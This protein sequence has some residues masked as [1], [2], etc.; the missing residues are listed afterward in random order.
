M[1]LCHGWY[2][3]KESLDMFSIS[4]GIDIVEI[5]R[6]EK[7]YKKFNKKFINR[8][9]SNEEISNIQFESLSK[10]N[11]ANF[12]AARYACKEACAKAA[13]TGFSNGLKFTDFKIFNDKLGKPVLII[14]EKVRKM[15]KK[16]FHSTISISHEK[17]FAIASVIFYF[18]KNK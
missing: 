17:R 3:V 12:L 8:I 13:G 10:T 9:L 5:K 4:H 15:I 2:L 7:V 18:P 11:I 16:D 1:E 6:V 14:S